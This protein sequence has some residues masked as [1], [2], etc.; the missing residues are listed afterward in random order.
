MRTM[1]K[2]QKVKNTPNRIRN[3]TIVKEAMAKL[4]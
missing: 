1:V 2:D 3:T 4:L